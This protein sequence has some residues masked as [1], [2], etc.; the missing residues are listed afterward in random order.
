MGTPTSTTAT[1]VGSRAESILKLI[2]SAW[3]QTARRRIFSC[4]LIAALSLGVRL[5]LLRVDPKPEPQVHDEFAYIFG[6]ETLVKSRLTTPTHP[7]W[8]F[9]QTYHINMQP[10]YASKYPPAQ[11][12]FL[13]LGIRLFGHPWYGVVITVSLMCGCICWMLQGWVPAGYALLGGLFAFLQFGVSHYWI[14]SYWGGAVPAIG[15]ALVFGAL[16]RLARR[17]A[18]S[19][20][21]AAAVG[22]AILANSR[23]FEGFVLVFLASAAA[24]LWTWGRLGIWLHPAIVVPF[25]VILIS[26]AGAMAY[27]NFRLTGSPTTLPYSLNQQR[28]SAAPLLWI[29]PPYAPKHREYRDPSMREFWE[30]WDVG[31]YTRARHNPLGVVFRLY[32]KIR[33]LIG[34]GAG[35]IL[36]FLFAC[37]IPLASLPRLRLALG[38]VVL[39]LCVMILDKYSFAH[40]LAPALGAYFVVAMFGLR[41]LRCHRL[42]ERRMGRALVACVVALAGVLFLF[43]SVITIYGRTQSTDSTAV[44][45]RR[46]V[47]ARLGSQAGKHLVLV[48][49]AANHNPHEEIIY[50]SPDIDAQK[51]VWAFDFGLEADRPLLDYYRDRKVWLIQPDGPHPTLERYSRN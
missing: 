12:A 45:F 36:A 33:E 46:Q 8:L 18:A 7:M 22:I 23:P 17:G 16:P 28:Y 42:G 4:L 49:Y 5:A 3:V 30:S 31:Y 25:A 39:F 21:C 34:A 10:T 40:Y 27:Y 24:I 43:D 15:G 13:A 41:L 19:V 26:T 35:L 32:E 6:A 50:N 1:P 14:D 29:M 38:V 9:F 48:R 11:S 20:A 2:E 51:I 37:A 44:G 47:G